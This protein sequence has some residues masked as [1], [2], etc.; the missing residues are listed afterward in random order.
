[1]TFQETLIK[2][3]DLRTR[4]DAGFSNQDKASISSL[5]SEVLGKS[6]LSTGC[7]DCHRDALIEV[8]NYLKRE[9]KMKEKCDYSL[10]NGVVLQ[11]FGTSE[12]YTNANLTNEAAEKYLRT[13]PKAADSLFA[14]TPNDLEEILA[15]EEKPKEEA[16]I[17]NEALVFELAEKLAGNATKKA[18]KEE[19]KEYE[20]EGKKVT[21]KLL[22]AHIKAADDLNT[23]GPGKKGE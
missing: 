19:Y 18:L 12:V 20:I 3:N 17:L 6:V 4:I 7:N 2:V 15:K 21:G 14:H 16:V 22:D 9:G 13:F 23:S 10:K 8:Y 11:I 5:Y 1:M